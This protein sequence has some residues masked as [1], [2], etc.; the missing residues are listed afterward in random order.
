MSRS[1]SLCS[2]EQNQRSQRAVL[3]FACDLKSLRRRVDPTVHSPCVFVFPSFKNARGKP[4]LKQSQVFQ[5]FSGCVVCE[6]S[7]ILR[8]FFS[9]HHVPSYLQTTYFSGGPRE[10]RPP[11][12]QSPNG[13][14][15]TSFTVRTARSITGFK[16]LSCT[17]IAMCW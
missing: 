2:L 6:I 17:E 1:K 7:Q 9:H 12:G 10:T 5:A 16:D 4:C 15:P 8:R 11:N 13:S 3:R 14:S